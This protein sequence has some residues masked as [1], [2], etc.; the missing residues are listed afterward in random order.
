VNELFGF[1]VLAAVLALVFSRTPGGRRVYAKLRGAAGPDS[2]PQKAAPNEDHAFLLT[3]CDGDEDELLR[4]LEVE[5][6][7]NP[8]LDEAQVYRRAIRSWFQEKRGGTHGEP[9]GEGSEGSDT[10]L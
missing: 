1:V 4:R 9:G 3:A 8:D 5:V 2:P 6:R 10:W 7:R